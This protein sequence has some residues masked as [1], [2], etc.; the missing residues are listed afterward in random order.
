VR[1]PEGLLRR[2]LTAAVLLAVFLGA[3]LLL[4]KRFFGTLAAAVLVL[5]GLEWGRL[6]GLGAPPASR[7]RSNVSR[8]S[9]SFRYISSPSAT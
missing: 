5:A 4:D 9:L 7:I 8:T 6:A 2:V 1:S 3:L